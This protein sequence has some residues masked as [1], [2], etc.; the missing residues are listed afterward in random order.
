MFLQFGLYLFV[1]S[2]IMITI[3]LVL[4]GDFITPKQKQYQCTN[5]F[6]K[7]GSVVQ[8]EKTRPYSAMQIKRIGLEQFM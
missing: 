8:L 3:P 7:V 2:F 4:S 1:G 5:Q 6:K